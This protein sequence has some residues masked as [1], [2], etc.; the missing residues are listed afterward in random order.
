MT[1][2]D[3][4]IWRDVGTWKDMGTR[5]YEWTQ[6]CVGPWGYGGDM[7]G[8]GDSSPPAPNL[9]SPCLDLLPFGDITFGELHQKFLAVEFPR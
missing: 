1:C 8:H 6:G 2:R 7:G 9:T 3:M 5:G 4:E